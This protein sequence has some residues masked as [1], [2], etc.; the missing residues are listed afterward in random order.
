MFDSYGRRIHYL[1]VS[2]TDRCN[3][4]CRYCM[5]AEGVPWLPH[6]SILSYEQIT[7]LVTVAAGLGFDKVRLTGGEPLARKGMVGLVRL[8][9]GIPGISQLGMTT[10]GIL[11]LPLASDLA[12]SGLTS[13]NISLDT[14]DPT[15][16]E[17]MTR[18]GQLS[19]AL[20]GIRA[21]RAAGLPVKLNVVVGT[22]QGSGC[23]AGQAGQ[24]DPVADAPAS[25]VLQPASGI[26]ELP[27][28][29]AFAASL[30]CAV[31]TIRQY[32]LDE[33][34]RDDGDFMR[35]PP[36]DDCNRI[37]L[38][39]DGQLRPCLHGDAT[40]PVDWSDIE[41]SLRACVALKPP[42]GQQ[43]SHHFVNSIGG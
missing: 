8:L 30:G 40:L 18:G 23:P 35:P 33:P 13:V 9:A 28:I 24:A 27:A 4:R 19:E 17:Y 31:Q 7:R 38:L 2:V 42:C 11:L 41:G 5:P 22:G 20:A 34:K 12:A 29:E 3:L 25:A 26:D 15:R 39:A 14:L 36:C 32:R 10:N 16:Y 43:A 1:R 6:D 21:A 37:R